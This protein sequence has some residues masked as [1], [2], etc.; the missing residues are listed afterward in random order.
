M[1]VLLTGE[2]GHCNYVMAPSSELG[3]LLHLGHVLCTR[4]PT[5][6]ITGFRREQVEHQQDKTIS[7]LQ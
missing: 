3:S 6:T 7:V 5:C 4:V 2:S 1:Q